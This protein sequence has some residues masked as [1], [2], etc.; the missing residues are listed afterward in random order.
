L[1]IDLPPPCREKLFYWVVER[2]VWWKA[3]I[4]RTDSKVKAGVVP[5]HDIDRMLTP[6][7]NKQ[8]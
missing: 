3:N 2:A 6:V 1:A 7:A 5:H 8:S 4:G